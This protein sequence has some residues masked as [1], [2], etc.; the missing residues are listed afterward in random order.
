MNG[1]GK[2]GREGGRKEKEIE[3]KREIE[4]EK[5]KNMREYYLEKCVKILCQIE[6]KTIVVDMGMKKIFVENIIKY[7]W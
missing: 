3:G 2:R 1:Y 5:R 6:S 7:K 4:R